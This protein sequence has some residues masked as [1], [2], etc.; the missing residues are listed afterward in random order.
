[1]MTIATITLL[2]GF[3]TANLGQGP[4]ALQAGP[5]QVQNATDERAHGMKCSFA[6]V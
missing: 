3:A 4:P 1:M 2:V 6:H 5:L